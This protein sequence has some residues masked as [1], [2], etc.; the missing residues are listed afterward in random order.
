MLTGSLRQNSIRLQRQKSGREQ[1]IQ[2]IPTTLQGVAH[3]SFR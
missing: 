3:K 2:G 1:N